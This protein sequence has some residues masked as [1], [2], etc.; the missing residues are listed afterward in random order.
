MG[1]KKVEC[2]LIFWKFVKLHFLLP[3]DSNILRVFSFKHGSC[4]C[5]QVRSFYFYSYAFLRYFYFNCNI[6]WY[7]NFSHR[8]FCR[9]CDAD[10]LSTVLLLLLVLLIIDSQSQVIKTNMRCG[11]IFVFIVKIY[12]MAHFMEVNHVWP[13][14]FLQI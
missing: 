3:A 10:S 6:L 14:E 7:G 4:N 11:K 5:R 8:V 13:L 2:W 12:F 1:L 9:I